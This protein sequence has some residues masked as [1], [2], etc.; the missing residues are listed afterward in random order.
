MSRKPRNLRNLFCFK[1]SQEKLA[2]FF[3]VI[4]DIFVES[5]WSI[6]GWTL[7]EFTGRSCGWIKCPA[8]PGETCFLN[9]DVSISVCEK[10]RLGGLIV[11]PNLMQK[12]KDLEII[13]G[14][15]DKNVKYLRLQRGWSKL[16]RI[17]L[18]S[19]AQSGGFLV[20]VGL[21]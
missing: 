5:C 20:Q 3:S 6:L 19:S 10:R 4:F 13:C 2:L 12:G 15:M 18:A 1:G 11:R 9:S 21:H 7:L 17:L 14:W 8:K 16:T